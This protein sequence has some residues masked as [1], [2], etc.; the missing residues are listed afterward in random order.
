MA[1]IID[2]ANI[3]GVRAYLTMNSH[4]E[5]GYKYDYEDKRGHYR[6][7]PEGTLSV[8][9]PPV[10]RQEIRDRVW[11]APMSGALKAF[12]MDLWLKFFRVLD[13]DC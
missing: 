11:G 9:A 6:P 4:G 3:S 2:R 8:V 10:L 7:G 5:C 13:R 1:V 12:V